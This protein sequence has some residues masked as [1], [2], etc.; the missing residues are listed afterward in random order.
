MRFL[1]FLQIKSGTSAWSH[2]FQD[3]RIALCVLDEAHQIDSSRVCTIALHVDEMVS[4]FDRAQ[5]LSNFSRSCQ[6]PLHRASFK[7]GT[8]RAFQWENVVGLQHCSKERI[9]DLLSPRSIKRLEISWR[10]GSFLARFMRETSESYSLVNRQIFSAGEKYSPKGVIPNTKIFLTWYQHADFFTMSENEILKEVRH[11]I[12]SFHQGASNEQGYDIGASYAIYANMLDEGLTLLKL[13][14]DRHL[15]FSYESI[16]P[17]ISIFHLNRQRYAF[18]VLVQWVLT[19][20]AILNKYGIRAPADV[21]SVWKVLTPHKAS[22]ATCIMCQ[23]C[24]LPRSDKWQD[25][26]GMRGD[27]ACR[28]VA[29]TR[30]RGFLSVHASH[31]LFL[32]DKVPD[33]WRKHLDVSYT[34][35]FRKHGD[36]ILVDCQDLKEVQKGKTARLLSTDLHKRVALGRQKLHSS[37]QNGKVPYVFASAKTLNGEQDG[38][39]KRDPAFTTGLFKSLADLCN[40]NC[41]ESS[42]DCSDLDSFYET[43]DSRDEDEESEQEQVVHQW[44]PKVLFQEMYFDVGLFKRAL[45]FWC[46]AVHIQASMTHVSIVQSVCMAALEDFSKESISSLMISSILPIISAEEKI[47]DLHVRV[48]PTAIFVANKVDQRHDI[49]L[50]LKIKTEDNDINGDCLDLVLTRLPRTM[51]IKVAALLHFLNASSFEWEML[52][53]A[54]KKLSAPAF[55]DNEKEDAFLSHLFQNL[56]QSSNSLYETFAPELGSDALLRKRNSPR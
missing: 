26:L 16:T 29:L 3:M 39:T 40:G 23:V 24:L 22:G 9:W 53:R 33:C 27:N 32:A 49:I 4:F 20:P 52:S 30:P 55:K 13:R 10:F 51:G 37:L 19:S 36:N 45:T 2:A 17:L 5:D 46:K 14:Q 6:R 42:D 56:E 11:P 41:E 35:W 1:C 7:L 18:D 47:K 28:D 12:R 50:A 54:G 15:D 21:R 25:F 31:D 44:I 38:F 8:K 34:D 48:T 43:S